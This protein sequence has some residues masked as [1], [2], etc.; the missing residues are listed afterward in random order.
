MAVA[1]IKIFFVKQ[2]T[3]FFGILG[4]SIWELYLT[5][6]R[7]KNCQIRFSSAIFGAL[8]FSLLGPFG[9]DLQNFQGKFSAEKTRE[10]FLILIREHYS[11]IYR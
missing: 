5:L 1:F 7:G 3:Y 4:K 11:E 2:S 10:K 8:F 9:V 6:S